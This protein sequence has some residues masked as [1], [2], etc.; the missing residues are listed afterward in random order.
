VATWGRLCAL[1]GA[2]TSEPRGPS[3]VGVKSGEIYES[4]DSA[5]G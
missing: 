4:E 5:K 1:C 2:L 3:T